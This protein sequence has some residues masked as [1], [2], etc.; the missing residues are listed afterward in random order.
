VLN[1]S[2]KSGNGD[3]VDYRHHHRNNN[4]NGN[5]NNNNNNN[6]NGNTST[7]SDN[8]ADDENAEKDR[9]D[10]TPRV[11]PASTTLVTS[12]SSP[13]FS[14]QL[15]AFEVWLRF[16]QIRQRQNPHG[17]LELPEQLPVVLQVLLSQV[18][19]IL[20]L[21]LLRQFLGLGL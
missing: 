18:H 11:T 14:E 15:T 2:A 6:I 7:S 8:N 13:F 20:A 5:G 19:C 9:P 1:M 4:N 16:A 17:Q 3:N 21:Q 10:L 12:V